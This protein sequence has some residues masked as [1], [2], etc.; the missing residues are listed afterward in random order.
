MPQDNGFSDDML[1]RVEAF[2]KAQGLELFVVGGAVRDRLLARDRA[3]RVA[4]KALNIDLAVRAEALRVA[5]A[6]AW[7]LSGSY[8]C[9]DE[10]TGSA[11][12]V[13][14]GDSARIELDLSDF[15]GPTLEEDLR[16]RDFA[17]NA[18]AVPLPAWL[19]GARWRQALIDPLRGQADLA[20]RRLV[21]CFDGTFRDDP[22]RILRAFRFAASLGFELDPSLLPLMRKAAS[23]LARV[24]GER[25]REELMAIFSSDRAGWACRALDELGVLDIICPELKAGRGLSQGGY[26]HLDVLGH[27]LET[28]AQCD[29]MLRDFAEFSPELREPM[30][31]YCLQPVVDG[32]TRGALIKL[33]GLYHDVGKP[34]T[35][36]VEADGDIWFLGHEHFGAVL[37][38]TLTERLKF[39]N[40]ERD[41]IHHLVLYHLR[42]GHLSREAQLTRR[43]IFRFFRD[44]GEDGPACLLVWWAD[45]LSTRGPVSRVDQIDEQ[46]ARLEELLRAYF[47]KVEEAVNPPRLIDGR[48]LMAHLRLPPGPLVGQLLQLV[49][50]AQAEGR[51]HSADE[52]LTLASQ[53]LKEHEA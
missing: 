32:R 34:A 33:S 39:S 14:G 30:A 41:L 43:A 16:H 37:V 13:V 50:E 51:V 9:L 6:L 53:A 26:H 17:I 35:R 12:I 44:L 11:R 49:Q 31:A 10:D 24:S 7:S 52:A 27:E 8:V 15:R 29:R 46:R 21:A 38:D 45:R 40:R 5:K 20:A 1:A 19:D 42:P 22:V 48:T 23:S 28:V 47:L 36:R 18:I 2:A 3:D 4:G 25:V